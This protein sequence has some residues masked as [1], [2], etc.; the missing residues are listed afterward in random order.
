MKTQLSRFHALQ[1][2]IYIQ[3]YNQ[4]FF[5]PIHRL[6][7]FSRHRFTTEFIERWY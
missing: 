6:S 1:Y 2:T 4:Q 7:R 5:F 3:T